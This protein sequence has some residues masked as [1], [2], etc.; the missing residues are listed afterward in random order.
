MDFYELKKSVR[1]AW[2]WIWDS[3]SILSWI[4]ALFLMFIIVKFIFFPGMSLLMGTSLPLAGVESSSM[5]HQIVKDD[6][7]V[8]N[9]CGRVYSK[10]NKQ[11]IDFN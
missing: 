4:V 7:G 5:D 2:R 8:L 3:D 10:E 6:Y 11:Y 9:L 1:K